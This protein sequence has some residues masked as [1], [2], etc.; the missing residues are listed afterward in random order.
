MG[1]DCAR[2]MVR[3]GWIRCPQPA[4]GRGDH[5]RTRP[6][7]TG[8]STRPA[9]QRPGPRGLLGV[10]GRRRP[11]PHVAGQEGPSGGRP[12]PRPRRDRAGWAAT[13]P[14]PTRHPGARGPARASR[15]RRGHLEPFRAHLVR[16]PGICRAG[17]PEQDKT[18]HPTGGSAFAAN[19]VRGAALVRPSPHW[20]RPGGRAHRTRRH[21]PGPAADPAFAYACSQFA[22][23]GRSA[24]HVRAALAEG[25]PKGINGPPPRRAVEKRGRHRDRAEIRTRGVKNRLQRAT[26]YA[27]G[28]AAPRRRGECSLWHAALSTASS[29]SAC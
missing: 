7:Q 6:G 23:A 24:I 25:P 29:S 15:G 21:R 28:D 13:A 8:D 4:L 12:D 19:L 3:T 20:S 5:D 11:A 18:F 9:L 2:C 1:A 16:H 26:V 17:Y 27:G 14:A 10:E 22:P